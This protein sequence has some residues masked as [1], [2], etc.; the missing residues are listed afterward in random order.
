M[1]LAERISVFQE[2]ESTARALI[3]TDPCDAGECTDCDMGGAFF[4]ALALI[5]ELKEQAKHYPK[6]A[7][8]NIRLQEENAEIL[9][10]DTYTRRRLRDHL[11][12][13]IK[14][15]E[16]E[17]ERLREFASFVMAGVWE[18]YV[19]DGG[20]MEDKAEALGL[21]ELRTIDPED[22]IDGETEHYFL[23]WAPK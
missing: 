21:L 11:Q 16:A 14:M 20:D 22:S 4:E 7:G 23:V 9:R 1:T 19:M 17:N 12:T 8:E 6:V 15:L 13:P 5:E 3:H 2:F 18:N 10:P